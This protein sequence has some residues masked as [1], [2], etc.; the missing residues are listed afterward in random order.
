MI[1]YL[2]KISRTEGSQIYLFGASDTGKETSA[3]L[4]LVG[5][6]YTGF[7]DNSMPEGG[8]INGLKVF[9]LDVVQNGG[10]QKTISM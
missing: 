8:V 3:I 9:P 7:L 4:S 10:G 6:R 1:R 2:K 5:V